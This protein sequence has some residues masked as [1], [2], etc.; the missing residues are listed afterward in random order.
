MLIATRIA[1]ATDW[2]NVSLLSKLSQDQVSDLFM[3]PLQNEREVQR[4]I[5]T[6]DSTSIVEA[7]QHVYAQSG[8]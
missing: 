5:E 4:L 1:A 7:A 2:A 8:V 3:I 6:E